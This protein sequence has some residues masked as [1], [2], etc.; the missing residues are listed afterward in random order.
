MDANLLLVAYLWLLLSYPLSFIVGRWSARLAWFFTATFWF[1]IGYIVTTL[2]TTTS[3]V[4][5]VIIFA[6]TAML[7]GEKPD[8]MPNVRTRVR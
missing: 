1:A 7:E 5:A 8:E 2:Q 4:L 6:V 3:I